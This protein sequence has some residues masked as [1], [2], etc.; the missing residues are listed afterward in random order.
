MHSLNQP[1]LA[2]VIANDRVEI[3]QRRALPGSPIHP[4]P[5]YRAEFHLPVRSR[6]AY[7]AARLARR[8]D[9]VEAR[10]AVV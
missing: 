7:L 4:P 9:P 1:D 5:A 6:V 2:R 8:L 10:R 3:G